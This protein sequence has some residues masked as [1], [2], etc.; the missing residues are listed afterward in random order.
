VGFS[1]HLDD[2]PLMLTGFIFIDGVH[3]LLHLCGF[4]FRYTPSS[5]NGRPPKK[6][7]GTSGGVKEKPLGAILWIAAALAEFSFY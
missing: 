3:M 7:R 6:L 2:I 1:W 4:S 5:D